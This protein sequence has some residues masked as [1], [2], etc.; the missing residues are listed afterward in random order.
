M[1]E[2]SSALF[3]PLLCPAHG[4]LDIDKFDLHCAHYQQQQQGVGVVQ[5]VVRVI[6]KVL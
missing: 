6:N 4:C 2:Y 1:D 3:A 5:I